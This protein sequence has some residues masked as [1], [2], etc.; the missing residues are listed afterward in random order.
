MPILHYQSGLQNPTTKTLNATANTSSL[1]S[2]TVA[3]LG[4][5]S[6]IIA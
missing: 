1:V 2:E 3:V 4:K 5:A 6:A